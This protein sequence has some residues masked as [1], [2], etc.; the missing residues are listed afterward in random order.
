MVFDLNMEKRYAKVKPT[1]VEYVTAVRDYCNVDPLSTFECLPIET[2]EYK[3]V[4][5]NN[6]VL[7]E[8]NLICN[9]GDLKCM[10]FSFI[11]F[12]LIERYFD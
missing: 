12:C 6:G 2:E 11:L 4:S 7:G 1:L 3:I 10:K 5:K 8:Y 9:V